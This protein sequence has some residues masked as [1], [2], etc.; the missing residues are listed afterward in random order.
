MCD[1]AYLAAASSTRRVVPQLALVDPQDSLFIALLNEF[2][3]RG[4]L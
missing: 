3:G 1:L 4:G 2:R